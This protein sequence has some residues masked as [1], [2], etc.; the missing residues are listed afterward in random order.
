MVLK[1]AFWNTVKI[2]KNSLFLAF[3][4][5]WKA[6]NLKNWSIIMKYLYKAKVLNVIVA[7]LERLYDN[8]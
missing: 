2:Y 5:F 8:V 4:D 7:K 6:F 3:F 1:G